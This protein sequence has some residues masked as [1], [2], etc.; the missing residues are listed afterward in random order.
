MLRIFGRK[1]SEIYQGNGSGPEKLQRT[2]SPERLRR[3]LQDAAAELGRDPGAGEAAGI[4]AAGSGNF[5]KGPE[6]HQKYKA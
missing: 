4:G 5:G 2:G 6:S 1:P 3:S